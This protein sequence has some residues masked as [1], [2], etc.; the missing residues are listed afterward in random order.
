MAA[1]TVDRRDFNVIGDL[2]VESGQIDIAADG[3][4]LELISIKEIYYVAATSATDN[5]IGATVANA[6]GSTKATITWQIG[7]S[8]ENNAQFIAIGK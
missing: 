4:T 3:D 8:A 6:S 5:G 7:G 2:R 1:V